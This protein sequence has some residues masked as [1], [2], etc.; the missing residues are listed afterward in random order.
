[1]S[2]TA[3]DDL[4]R[5]VPE[6]LRDAP[7][8]L[9]EDGPAVYAELFRHRPHRSKLFR[10][11][12]TGLCGVVLQTAEDGHL[13]STRRWL[14]AFMVAVGDARRAAAAKKKDNGPTGKNRPGR[15][16]ATRSRTTNLGGRRR[17]GS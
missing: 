2:A 3:V 16:K 12:R 9:L 8:K 5:P 4:L 17:A 1:M 10:L 14:C 11:A 13:Y 7:F 6:D 15:K